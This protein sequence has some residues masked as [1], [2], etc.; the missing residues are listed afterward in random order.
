M[1]IFAI[2]IGNSNTR[3]AVVEDSKVLNKVQL[4]SQDSEKIADSLPEIY[5]KFTIGENLP[6]VV[7]SVVENIFR[8]LCDRAELALDIT[9]AVIGRDIP[10]PIELDLKDKKTVGTDR[11]VS[12]AMAYDRIDGAVAVA[13]FGTAITIDCVNDKGVFLGGAI[14]PG[15][16]ISLVSLAENTSALPEVQLESAVECPG[17]DTKGA[18]NAGVIFGAVGALREIVERFATKL[19]RW[20]E[21]ILT[22]G[23]A[24]I[25]RTHCDFADA[26]V[27][28][29]LIMGIEL[30]YEKW[31]VQ[32]DD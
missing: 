2:D 28:D 1:K 15:L 24:N 17:R 29:L 10:L 25:I 26:V 16:R 18:M 12:A 30:A 11:V 21:L 19:G 27:P 32:A 9:P 31:K 5:N 14:L 23:D 22:G 20:P 13:S 8:K 4:P 7:C 3:F 6:I